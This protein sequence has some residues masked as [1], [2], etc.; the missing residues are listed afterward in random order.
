MIEV[1][2]K[3]SLQLCNTTREMDQYYSR[4][5]QPANSTI[6]KSQGS[7]MKNFQVE[8]P[9]TQDPK[10]LSGPQRSTSNLQRSNEPSKKAWKEKKKEQ[11]QQD[12]KCRKSFTPTTGVNA[13]G[14]PHQK[15]KKIWKRLDMDLNT[16]ICFNYNKK[17]HYVNTCLDQPKN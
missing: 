15:K 5:S 11:H 16:I 6:A 8:K 10:S 13:A 1:E 17:G 12:W 3:A 4:G 7:N 9:K 14:E 2:D